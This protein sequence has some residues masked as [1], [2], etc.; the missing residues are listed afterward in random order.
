MAAAPNAPEE[1]VA[2]EINQLEQPLERLCVVRER[3]DGRSE[4]RDQVWKVVLL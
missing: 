1:V 3:V 2:I 4:G